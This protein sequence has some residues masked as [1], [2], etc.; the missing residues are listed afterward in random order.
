MVCLSVH[1]KQ[2]NCTMESA[3][4]EGETH[5]A[6]FASF[7]IIIKSDGDEIGSCKSHKEITLS[8]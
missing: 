5:F 4:L 6:L 7:C 2:L 8:S 3:A 1:S